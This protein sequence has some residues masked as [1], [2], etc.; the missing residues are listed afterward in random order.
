MQRPVG[1]AILCESSVGQVDK[2][3]H[4]PELRFA[5]GEPPDV[6]TTSID[7]AA[8]A[9]EAASFF[10]RKVGTDGFR[11]HHQA[12]LKKVVSDRRAS[13]DEETEIK[14]TIRKLV[15]TEF[16]RGANIPVVAF[17]ADSAA[18]QD[19]PRLTLVLVEPETE[20]KD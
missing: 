11:I 19:S 13:L 5:L 12:T 14:P 8:S 6:E 1:T 10:I 4:L 17:P 18:I 2:I 7:T 16:A 9:L 3:A 20:W 15:E